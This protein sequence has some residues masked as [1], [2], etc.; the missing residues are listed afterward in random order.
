ASFLR[1]F[2]TVHG[3]AARHFTPALLDALRAHPWPGNVR[4]LRNAVESMV[5]VS[6]GETLD[7]NGLPP[8]I[9]PVDGPAPAEATPGRMLAG[10]TIR[11]AEEHLVRAAL[12]AQ[13]GNRER[14]AKSLGISE[15]TLYR[16]IK[17]FN[18]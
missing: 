1:E 18:L 13:A 15:R 12:E 5:V 10:M 9:R 7:V 4:E 16:K 14:A 3:K 17:E 2:S 6:S 11:D 8:S